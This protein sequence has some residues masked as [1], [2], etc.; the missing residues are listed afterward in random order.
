MARVFTHDLR[1]ATAIG[2]HFELE[3]EERLTVDGQELLFLLGRAHVDTACC[4][5]GGCRYVV[6]PGWLLSWHSGRTAD[7]TPTSEVDPV[8]GESDRRRVRA[9]IG[10]RVRVNQVVFW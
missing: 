4:G 1:G 6:V 8:V 9:A 5:V 2:G 7:G 3:R 10:K